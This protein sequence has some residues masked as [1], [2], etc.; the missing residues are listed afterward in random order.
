MGAQALNLT[1][2]PIE[3]FR[4]Q[5]NAAMANQ[6]VAFDDHVEFYVV[7]LLCEFIDP[8]KIQAAFGDLDI[9]GTPLA[10]MLK[11]ALESPPAEQMRIY[12][13]LGDTS[14]YVTGFFQDYFNRKTFDMRYYIMLGANAYQNVSVIMREQH[15]EELFAGIFNELASNFVPL[16]DVVAEVADRVHVTGAVD[17]L[18]I[19]DRFLQS[20]SDRLR[21]LLQDNGIDPIPV[22]PK[23]K[24]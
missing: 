1:V 9:M 16:V 14:L 15:G 3:F 23:A 8:T 7:N 6:K 21:R 22:N 12:K 20:N 19:Y 11:H 24:Q 5:I 18:G 10:L 13:V 17:L 2:T 4:E